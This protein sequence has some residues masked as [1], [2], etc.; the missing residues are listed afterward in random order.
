MPVNVLT[1]EKFDT[2]DTRP[3]VDGRDGSGMG[4]EGQIQHIHSSKDAEPW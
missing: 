2:G 4:G 3:D 1:R